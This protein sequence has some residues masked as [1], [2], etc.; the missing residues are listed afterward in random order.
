MYYGAVKKFDVA[1]GEGIRT[2]LFVSGSFLTVT[3]PF[4]LLLSRTPYVSSL[5]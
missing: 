5:S 1:N 2:S 4:L 3:E